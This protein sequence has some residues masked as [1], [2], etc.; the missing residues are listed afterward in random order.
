MLSVNAKINRA[1]Q[2]FSEVNAGYAD[3]QRSNPIQQITECNEER[4]SFIVFARF[5]VQ[6][7]T[8]KWA[9]ICGEVL[10]DLRCAL[11]HIIYFQALS[12]SG[13]DPPASAEK[14][15]FPITTSQE[16]FDFAINRGQLTGLKTESINLVRSFQPFVRARIP[17]EDSLFALQALN[18]IDKHRYLHF[19]VFSVANTTAELSG[20]PQGVVKV[21]INAEPLKNEDWVISFETDGPC[22]GPEGEIR[23]SLRLGILEE[24]YRKQAILSLMKSCIDSVIEVNKCFQA[25]QG[26]ANA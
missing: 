21:S 12:D 7:E 8:A 14:L 18:N 13:L 11:D 2:L 19:A 4:T 26:G 22:P 9:L 15:M 17:E 20:L 23:Y 24:R 3:W 1:L 6:P 25:Y 10:F 16:R 5:I